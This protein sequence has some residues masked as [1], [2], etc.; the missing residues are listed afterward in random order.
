M[1]VD[2]DTAQI[3]RVKTWSLVNS[4]QITSVN[5]LGAITWMFVGARDV[6][7]LI[8]RMENA[9]MIMSKVS[10]ASESTSTRLKRQRELYHFVVI[11]G[12]RIVKRS[13]RV[14]HR[15]KMS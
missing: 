14:M 2:L 13:K 15:D 6:T 8:V 12:R 4:V 3:V 10:I 1:I 5:L 9:L 11:V 7:E